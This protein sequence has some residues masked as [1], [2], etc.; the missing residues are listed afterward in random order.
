MRGLKNRNIEIL[1]TK[2]HIR[3]IEI[4]PDITLE[5]DMLEIED[6]VTVEPLR[7]KGSKEGYD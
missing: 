5:E 1:K 6:M 3:L 2:F 4:I 7:H